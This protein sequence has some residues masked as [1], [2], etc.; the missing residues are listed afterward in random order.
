MPIAYSQAK[1]NLN[2]KKTKLKISY[3]I[4]SGVVK[5]AK[6]AEAQIQ[7]KIL[8]LIFSVSKKAV[9]LMSSVDTT[10]IYQQLQSCQGSSLDPHMS[11]KII[12]IIHK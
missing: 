4:E 1:Q 3:L 9:S 7:V 8:P 12:L 10:L 6:R 11:H 5:D 2:Q